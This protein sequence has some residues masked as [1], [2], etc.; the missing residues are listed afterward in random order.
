MPTTDTDTLYLRLKGARERLCVAQTL[1]P[2]AWQSEV[3]GGAIV[4]IDRVGAELPQWSRF[5]QPLASCA[6]TACSEGHTFKGGCALEVDCDIA[7]PDEWPSP[8][9][10]QR[11]PDP[12]LYAYDDGRG[13][14]RPDAWARFA[15]TRAE[16]CGTD[17]VVLVA[18]VVGLVA[19]G[20]LLGNVLVRV[21]G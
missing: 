4:A 18:A 12:P 6:G 3:L 21:L 5:D 7:E 13:G 1:A 16:R 8:A 15:D 17:Y 2:R 19:L 10:A 11:A 20:A 9:D 14:V